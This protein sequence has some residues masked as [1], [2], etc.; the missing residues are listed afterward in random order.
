MRDKNTSGT[1]GVKSES[2]ESSENLGDKEV[3][4]TLIED[5]LATLEAPI[6]ASATARLREQK[7]HQS[8]SKGATRRS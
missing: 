5:E 6:V 8:A 7:R 1:F 3:G 4:T 2:D